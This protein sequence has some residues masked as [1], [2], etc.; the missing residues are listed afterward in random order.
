MALE[1]QCMLTRGCRFN[2]KDVMV[3]VEHLEG[4][5]VQVEQAS[6]GVDKAVSISCAANVLHA[7]SYTVVGVNSLQDTPV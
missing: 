6:T 4:D 1:T 5:W 2:V 7:L 3:I